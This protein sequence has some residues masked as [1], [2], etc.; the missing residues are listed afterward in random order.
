MPVGANV[1]VEVGDGVGV[2][3]S[4]GVGELLNVGLG[5]G[6]IVGVVVGFDGRGVSCSPVA[7]GVWVGGM[8]LF[9]SGGLPLIQLDFI[10]S[11]F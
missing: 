4:D 2:D 7:V 8:D 10:F 1:G 11:G 9:S 3:V 6:V 5:V